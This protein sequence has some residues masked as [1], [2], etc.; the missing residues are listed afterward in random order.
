MVSIY[1]GGGK[2][3][4]G[5]KRKSPGNTQTI[6]VTVDDW[7]SRGRG[8]CRTHQPIL[9]VDGALPGETCQVAV[10]QR[11]KQVCEGYVTRV[12]EPAAE[13]QTPFCAVYSQCGGCQLQH[14]ERD[15]ALTWRQA[16]LDSQ[17]RHKHNLATLNWVR[18]VKS[19]SDQYRRKTR[20]AIDAR[21]G[22]PLALGFRAR[23]S[24]A[25]VNV[26]DCPVLEP[27]LNAML[28][29]LHQL[30]EQLNGRAVIGH[31]SLLRADNG[32][33]ITLR[34]TRQLNGHDQE[35]LTAFAN[36]HQVTLRLD[37]G[38]NSDTLYNPV[39][40]LLCAT[41]DGLSLSVTTEDFIQVNGDVNLAMIHQALDWLAPEPHHKV[42]DLF[43]G[44]GN[45]SLPMAKR[46]ASVTAVEGVTTMVQRAK[47]IAHEQGIDN[48]QWYTADLSNEAE[49]AALAIKK[50]DKVLLDP[51][52]EGAFEACQQIASARVA[53][54]VYVSCNPA[55]FNRDLVPLL[56]GGYRIVKIG[57]MEMFPYT[58]HIESMA[59][60]ERVGKG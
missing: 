41:A 48:I 56:A 53:S 4:S 20:L 39:E 2:K 44:L 36:E 8:V 40:E 57:I 19:H 51:S 9:F 49:L 37:Y 46:C 24:D 17:I 27:G 22:K 21:K 29:P 5:A 60:L 23:K 42:L 52:R 10:T 50:Y 14:V 58:Q 6:T 45:F 13:R 11:K 26:T 31:I 33:G 30:V 35:Q 18:P 7:E 32:I 3:R 47:K 59:L 34:C 38:D 25:V 15:A 12:L 1:Q 16:A 28:P 54:I 43:S 55:T